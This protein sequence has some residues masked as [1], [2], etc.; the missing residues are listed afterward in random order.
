M[1][2]LSGA[3]SRPPGCVAFSVSASAAVFLH[4]KGRVDINGEIQKATKKLD[5]MRTAIEKQNKILGD[6]AYTQ[7]VSQELQEAEK[8]KLADLETERKAFEETIKQFEALKLE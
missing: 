8:K 5:K 4:V 1:S 3:D 2:I 7:K 6:P